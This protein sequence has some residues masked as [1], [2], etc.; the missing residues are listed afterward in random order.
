MWALVWSLS[1]MHSHVFV[2]TGRLRE[3]LAA[4]CAL[5]W[6]VLFV[7]V[8]DMNA[9]PITLLKGAVTQRAGELPVSV[10]NTARVFKVAVTVIS[11]GKYFA[12][13]L[14]RITCAICKIKN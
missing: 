14:T 5:V 13:T 8:K 2:K 11:V 9:Q 6:T 12:T 10:V 1:T 4:F 7:H 3:A